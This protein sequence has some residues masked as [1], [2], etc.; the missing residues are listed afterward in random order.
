[1]LVAVGSVRGAPGATTLVLA[2]ASRWRAVVGRPAVVVEADP[3]GGCLA[4]R[5]GLAARP[6][7]TELAG[8]A[9]SGL[10]D[11][12][13][14]WAFAQTA[15]PSGGRREVTVVVG[16]AAAEPAHAALRAA[17]E[18]LGAGLGTAVDHD[19]IVDAGRLRPGSP[20]L[21][22]VAGA[23]ERLVVTG[24]ELEAVVALT[25]RRDLLTGLGDWQAVVD[26]GSGYAPGEIEQ[27]LGV[28]VVGIP[29]HGRDRQRER[30]LDSLVAS[31]GAARSVEREEA[32]R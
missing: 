6:G 2:V 20:A 8:A 24:G 14:V 1:M 4:A 25:S 31:L 15:R 9:R 32:R 12:G 28:V 17:A 5:L 19:V 30:A 22:L 10:A 21:P 7:L 29:R 26:S 23:D 13:D 16:P 11:P 18:P 27:V 3:D